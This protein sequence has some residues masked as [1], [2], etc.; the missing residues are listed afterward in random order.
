MYHHQPAPQGE[1][2][3][4]G[5]VR[6]QLDVANLFDLDRVPVKL[7]RFQ[8]LSAGE[9]L[10]ECLDDEFPPGGFEPEVVDASGNGMN[11]DILNARDLPCGA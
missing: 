8:P 7:A 11:L 5:R 3:D 1:H 2:D 4:D 9:F 6:S 10:I